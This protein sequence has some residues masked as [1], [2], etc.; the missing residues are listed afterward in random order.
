MPKILSPRAVSLTFCQRH[1]AVVSQLSVISM[2]P[3]CPRRSAPHPLHLSAP[4]PPSPP[5]PPTPNLLLASCHHGAGQKLIS[6]H[7]HLTVSKSSSPW[8]W[9]HH[10]VTDAPWHSSVTS[11]LSLG[12]VLPA[13]LLVR[14]LNTSMWL[15]CI[16]RVNIVKH[17]VLVLSEKSENPQT[18]SRNMSVHA[19][20]SYYIKNYLNRERFSSHFLFFFFFF[21][22]KKWGGMCGCVGG[23]VIF[24]TLLR[25]TDK[26]NCIR[27]AKIWRTIHGG[28]NNNNNN[29]NVSII[30]SLD[31]SKIFFEK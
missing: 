1:Y 24:D 17:I 4:L 28:K 2:Q 7:W 9:C 23:W 29:N 26:K 8:S 18:F 10:S 13:I 3:T 5:P 20:T 31:E 30:K 6:F 11:F 25:H 12:V 19:V 22:E 15:V 21:R 16:L 14:S 27:K